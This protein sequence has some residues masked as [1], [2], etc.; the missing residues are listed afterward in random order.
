MDSETERVDSDNEGVEKK[1]LT[2]ERKGYI[3]RN[4]PN[5]INNIDIGFCNTV[6]F[7]GANN[8]IVPSHG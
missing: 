8:E 5:G 3:I 4:P 7:I 2:P 6:Y 1:V